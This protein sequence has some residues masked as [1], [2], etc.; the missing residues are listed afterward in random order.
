MKIPLLTFLALV[1]FAGNSLLCRA[2]LG[3]KSIGPELFTLIR[4][5]SGALVLAAIL[6]GKSR[7]RNPGQ[8]SSSAALALFLYA[9]AFAYAYVRIDAGV[10]ALVLFGM[11]Q[12]T[13]FGWTLAKK[14]PPTA[15]EWLG[16]AVALS[17]LALLTLPGKNSPSLAGLALMALAGV[18]WGAY[19]LM[20]RAGTNPLA[21]TSTN[22]LLAA[23]FSLALLALPGSLAGASPR[24]AGLAVLSGAITS[25]LGYTIWYSVLPSLGSARAGVVQLAVPV[26]ALLASSALL[27][28][29]VSGR[30]VLSAAL[31]LGGIAIALSPRRKF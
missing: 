11:V 18:S 20:G 3:T 13:M 31:I 28:E 24:G 14:H 21:A 12:L 27:G 1:C 30:L 10:G 26:I 5:G 16:M 6:L 7:R 22:F 2:A 29:S 9:I 8:G 23:I 17:G 4:L 25:G 15:A 19:T